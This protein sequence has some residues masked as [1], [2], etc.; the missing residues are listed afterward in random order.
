MVLRDWQI[1]ICCLR[2]VFERKLKCGV[3]WDGVGDGFL[4][5]PEVTDGRYSVFLTSLPSDLQ[6]MGPIGEYSARATTLQGLGGFLSW[7]IV[8]MIVIRCDGCSV[9]NLI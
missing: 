2:G 7:L 4:Y 1:I 5:C 9:R 3:E 6:V 8:P